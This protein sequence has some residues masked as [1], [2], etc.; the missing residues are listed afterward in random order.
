MLVLGLGVQPCYGGRGGSVQCV[1][2]SDTAGIPWQLWPRAVEVLSPVP[3][4][5]CT[6]LG[7]PFGDGWGLLWA[8]VPPVIPIPSCPGEHTAMNCI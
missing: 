1:G 2:Y 6:Y 8:A 7:L 3:V 5:G 4:F